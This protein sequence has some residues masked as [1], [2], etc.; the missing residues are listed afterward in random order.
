MKK[1]CL[2]CKALLSNLCA[3]G[4]K[5][6][7]DSKEVYVKNKKDIVSFYRPSEN[8]PKP[9]TNKKLVECVKHN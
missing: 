4:Y 5:I 8:C 3:L 6:V 2:G 1:S 9:M 7:Y